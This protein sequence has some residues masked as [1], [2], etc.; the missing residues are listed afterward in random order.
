VSLSIYLPHQTLEGQLQAYRFD[1][2]GIAGFSH[3]FKSLHDEPSDVK[4]AFEAFSDLKPSLVET[5]VFLISPVFPMIAHIPTT[6][7][8]LTKKLN[9][10]LK[11]I[12]V[13]LLTESSI[14]G[15]QKA[16]DKSIIGLLRS[17]LFLIEIGDWHGHLCYHPSQR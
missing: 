5:A 13:K 11:T 12:A 16:V 14:I 15:D 8:N 17:F 4:A 10:S 3:D 2:V 1:S 6:I 9:A 7:K